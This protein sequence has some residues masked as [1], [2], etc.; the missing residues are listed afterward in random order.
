M[1][2]SDDELPPEL[3]D[4]GDPASI[5]ATTSFKKVPIS[6]ITG[7]WTESFDMPLPHVSIHRRHRLA[8]RISKANNLA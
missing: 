1:V 5:D 7:K 3:I 6:I 8:T 2:D 4:V